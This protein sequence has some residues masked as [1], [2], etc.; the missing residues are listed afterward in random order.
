MFTYIRPP[1][2]LVSF[3]SG[4]FGLRGW[5]WEGSWVVDGDDDDDD[6]A[7]FVLMLVC[8]V[9]HM[10]GLWGAAWPGFLVSSQALRISCR[11]PSEAKLSQAKAK[12]SEE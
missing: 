6:D 10:G 2:L 9:R 7:V 4:V 8:L 1:P 3:V 11:Q 5:R 12:P